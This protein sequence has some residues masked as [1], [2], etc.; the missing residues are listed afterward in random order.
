MPRPIAFL[1][2][3]VVAVSGAW[4]FSVM[5]R[6]RGEAVSSGYLV[7]AAM[8]T[9]AIGYRFYS[10]WLAAKALMLDRPPGLKAAS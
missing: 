4:A 1:A 5:A 9:Y 8:C 10:K 2:W 7:L 6:Q 3:L